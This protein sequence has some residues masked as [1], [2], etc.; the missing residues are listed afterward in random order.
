VVEHVQA[1]HRPNRGVTERQ[2]RPVT[3]DDGPQ[4]RGLMCP[5]L[6]LFD[7]DG[8]EVVGSDTGEPEPGAAA[9]VEDR[10]SSQ[11]RQLVLD[12]RERGRSLGLVLGR[13]PV[14]L[15]ARMQ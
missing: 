5:V 1:P 6:V 4:I 12:G 3:D 9:E 2:S 13:H 15:R 8:S 11:P 14:A 7:P 10:A